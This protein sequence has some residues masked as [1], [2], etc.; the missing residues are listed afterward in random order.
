MNKYDNV[1]NEEIFAEEKRKTQRELFQVVIKIFL[2]L[3]SITVIIGGV[4]FGSIGVNFFNIVKRKD[5]ETGD[6]ATVVDDI[7]VRP[8]AI[9]LI[10]IGTNGMDEQDNL[11]DSIN[12]IVVNPRGRFAEIVAIPRDSFLPAGD[13]CGFETTVY[14]KI[15]HYGYSNTC[16]E[17]TSEKL[18]DID[19][20]YYI[21]LNFFGLVDIIDALGGIEMVVP[22][23]REG[24]NDYQG[25]LAADIPNPTEL[26]DGEQW[27]EHDHYR[28]PF[29]V[30]FTEFGKQK[31]T[32]EQALAL[33]RTRYYDSDF[34]RSLRQTELIIAILNKIGSSVTVFSLN[35]ILEVAIGN[36]ETNIATNQ[37]MDFIRLSRNLF[38]SRENFEFRTTQLDGIAEYIDDVS[39]NLVLIPSI[40]DIR[41]KLIYALMYD[42]SLK[43]RYP[44][45][46]NPPQ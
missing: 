26:Q 20:N 34:A 24:F 16:L 8:F 13:A 4:Y 12:V 46:E 15:A 44:Q 6:F 7:N 27:C 9:L 22:D 3:L 43:I 25:D 38:G 33:T 41:Q 36:V 35:Q 28:N 10:G 11:A 14:D 18:F 17:T 31:V 5:F 42:T 40:E 21:Q 1:Y 2:L 23:L 29:A 45:T 19:I 37:F 32:G 30:C 39:V